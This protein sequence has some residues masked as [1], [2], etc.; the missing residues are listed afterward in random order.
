MQLGHWWPLMKGNDMASPAPK[1][2]PFVVR[3]ARPSTVD[4]VAEELRDAIFTGSLPPGS[5]IMEVHLA[6]QLGVSRGPLREATQRLVQQGLLTAHPGRGL[7]VAVI[8]ADQAGDVYRAR[9]AVE[10]E[11]LRA[12]VKNPT[13]DALTTLTSHLEALQDAITAGDAM[14]VGNAQLAFHQALVDLAGSQ[15][16]SHYMATL[17]I[18]TRIAALSHPA[19]YTVAGEL[20]PDHRQLIT[21]IANGDILAS[22]TC[23][24]TLLTEAF[25]H[26]TNLDS[27]TLTLTATPRHKPPH[28]GPITRD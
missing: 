26:L 23:L 19:G 25:K 16:L 10:A 14:T 22:L 17:V 6:N 21:S 5:S 28:V 4:L 8:E 27:K 18:E 12:L 15:R 9:F 11:A 2:H 3:V 24:H 13:N 20:S 7:Y 1:S